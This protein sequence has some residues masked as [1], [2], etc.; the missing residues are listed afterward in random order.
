VLTGRADGILNPYCGN[1]RR[2]TQANETL[3]MPK[4]INKNIMPALDEL[5]NAQLQDLKLKMEIEKLHFETIDK[6]KSWLYKN[7]SILIPSFIALATI[8]TG[9][10]SGYFS[11]TAIK[12]ENQKHDLQDSINVFQT[13]RDSLYK[14]IVRLKVSNDSLL[15]IQKQILKDN[16]I[17]KEANSNLKLKVDSLEITIAKLSTN[18]RVDEFIISTNSKSD[19]P[20]SVTVLNL[21]GKVIYQ[22]TTT[23]SSVKFG[24]KFPPGIYLVRVEKDNQVAIQKLVKGK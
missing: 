7:L 17:L 14:Q 4:R 5:T 21:S 3:K 23:Q 22:V 18:P 11:A 19:S 24:D 6:K 9:I 2:C 13:K 16:S 10:V 12:L 15:V 20:M 8:A 1:A